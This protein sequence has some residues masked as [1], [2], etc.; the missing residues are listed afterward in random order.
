MRMLAT[1]YAEREREREEM[2]VGV[3]IIVDHWLD[4]ESQSNFGK[5]LWEVLLNQEL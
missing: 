1:S 2:E 4:G 3:V 5:E